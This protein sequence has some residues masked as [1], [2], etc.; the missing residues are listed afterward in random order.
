M[1]EGAL[2]P[3]L[4]FALQG[5]ATLVGRGAEAFVLSLGAA[6]S[7]FALDGFRG[8]PVLAANAR[9]RYFAQGGEAR[10]AAEGA[11]GRPQHRRAGGGERR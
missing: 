8:R 6:P 2:D 7:R 11:R 1:L 4:M 5:G 9:H 3:S 10:P